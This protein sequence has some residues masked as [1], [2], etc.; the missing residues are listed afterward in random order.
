MPTI[1]IVIPTFRR[2]Y[3]LREALTSITAQSL[4]TCGAADIAEPVDIEVLVCDNGADEATRRIVS[5]LAD[6]RFVYVPRPRNL[7]MMRNAVA[8]FM[9]A[10]GEFALKLDDDDLLHPDALASLYEPFRNHPDLTVAFGSLTLID[11]T[12]RVLRGRTAAN[13]AY[14]GRSELIP[15][16]QQPF[17]SI[18]FSGA[19]NLACALVRRDAIDWHDIPPDVETA[20]DR[21][22]ALQASRDGAAAWFVGRPLTSYRIHD[23]SDSTTAY[24]RQAMG[25]LRAMEHAIDDGR[26][27]NS[28]L[29]L[30]GTQASALR[31]A[32]A[33]LNEDRDALRLTGAQRSAAARRVLRRALLRRRDPALLRLL[34]LALLPR[35]I[36]SP[37]ARRRQASYKL[38]MARTQRAG[39]PERTRPAPASGAATVVG[40]LHRHLDVV[41]VR[42]LQPRGRDT[43]ELPLALQ[44][45][46][47]S[48]AD[49]EH[50]LP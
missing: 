34:A 44:L 27:L 42:L 41:R 28:R 50:R 1:G 18:V 48:R 13:E 47:R 7:G 35:F 31:A 4:L 33:L 49:V 8:G 39:H 24:L 45:R 5:E 2:P 16:R 14:S 43:D 46:D 38:R 17:E 37:I 22:I 3:Y 9:E 15:G 26:H 20:Y 19:V 29:L 40:R 30:D 21:H 23:H 36:G 12:G 32:R 6:P 25:S 11:A 10:R